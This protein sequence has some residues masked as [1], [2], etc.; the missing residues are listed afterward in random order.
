[1]LNSNEASR[2]IKEDKYK[3]LRMSLILASES[4]PDAISDFE[5]SAREIDSMNQEVFENEISKKYYE[6]KTLEE[7][8]DRLENLIT[9]IE[10]RVFQRDALKEDYYNVTGIQL[11]GL[12]PVRDEDRLFQYKDRLSYIKEYLNNMIEI[13]NA[14]SDIEKYNKELEEAYNDKT[15]NEKNNL[16]YENE[17]LELFK[18]IVDSDIYSLENKDKIDNE[19]DKINPSI[20]ES[21]KSL[22][23]FN[24]S[25]TSLK[26]AGISGREER[27]YY[28]YVVN[29]R[30]DYYSKMEKYFLLSLFRL[31]IVVD[32][33]FEQV[34]N[35]RNKIKEILSDRESLRANLEINNEDILQ[36]LVKVLDKQYNEIKIQANNI[37]NIT[38]LKE[39][40]DNREEDLER[41]N[42]DNQKLEIISL[43][44]EYHIIEDF[45]E[46]ILENNTDDI[47]NFSEMLDLNDTDIKDSD[48]EIEEITDNM[49]ISVKDSASLD[50]IKAREKAK[51]VMIKVGK[52]L[53][54]SSKEQTIETPEMSSDKKE[55]TSP[56]VSNT[57]NIPPTQPIQS[58]NNEINNINIPGETPISEELELPSYDD[59]PTVSSLTS[60]SNSNENL[61]NNNTT[62]FWGNEIDSFEF[63]DLNSWGDK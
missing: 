19:L 22:D 56:V 23:I 44:R 63:P 57:N 61:P 34:F 62:S 12:E 42:D 7:E 21:K 60:K 24:K 33:T 53:E 3:I 43:L 25:F 32:N 37:T 51:S 26:K 18:K 40:I 30:N 52:M 8:K 55:I 49:V 14:N 1:M 2:K 11:T 46:P 15:E 48:N 38:S 47:Y 6:T 17:L 31:I 4:D 59:L 36:P 50:I 45:E 9:F 20:L 28:S 39:K 16:E 54:E 10:S 41:Y 5:T 29:A 35:K 58:Q 27:E 13:E